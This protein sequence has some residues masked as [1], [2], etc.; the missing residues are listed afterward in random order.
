[1]SDITTSLTAALNQAVR[2][3]SDSIAKDGLVVLRSVLSD[4]GFNES[5]YLK[6]YKAYAH[7]GNDGIIFEIV[8]NIE[9]VEKTPAV[10]E[11]MNAA[12]ESAEQNALQATRSFGFEDGQLVRVEQ[13]KD[14]RKGSKTR[15]RQPQFVDKRRPSGDTT[16][17]ATTRLREHEI[18]MHAPRSLFVNREGKLSMM[19]QRSVRTTKEGVTHLPQGKFEGIIKSFLD[20][21]KDVILKKFTPELE[22]ILAGYIK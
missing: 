1:M 14:I 18:A 13:F 19:F 11:Q 21:L 22:K 3:V 10:Q 16:K 15:I 8:L 20:Q 17:G 9:A 2:S 4:A 7:V 6:D 5:E 12:Q